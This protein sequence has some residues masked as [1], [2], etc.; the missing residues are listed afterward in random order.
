MSQMKMFGLT[1]YDNGEFSFYTTDH[2]GDIYIVPTPTHLQHFS[3]TTIWKELTLSSLS[4]L[5]TGKVLLSRQFGVKRVA[6]TGSS[7]VLGKWAIVLPA[8]ASH[9]S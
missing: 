4:Y 2:I 6:K 8:T 7:E 9:M 3:M 1:C 5:R